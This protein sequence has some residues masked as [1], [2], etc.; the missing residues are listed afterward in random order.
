MLSKSLADINLKSTMSRTTC[1]FFFKD[2]DNITKSNSAALSVLLHQLFQAKPSLIHNAMDAYEA[3]EETGG[4]AQSFHQLWAVLKKSARDPEAGEIICI[5]DALDECAEGDRNELINTL[6]DFYNP[7]SSDQNH[8]KLKFFVTSR[9]YRDIEQEFIALTKHFPTIRIRGEHESPAI[10]NDI[11]FVVQQKISELKSDLMLTD[12][13]EEKFKQGLQNIKQRTFLWATLIIPFIRDRFNSLNKY[14]KA[15]IRTL[16]PTVEKEYQAILS[17]IKDFNR[18]TARKLLLILVGAARPLSLKELNI[19]LAIEEHHK[20]HEDLRLDPEKRFKITVRDLCGLFVTVID[21]KAFL[22]HQTA[23]DFLLAQSLDSAT[24]RQHSPELETRWQHSLE[25]V[26]SELVMARSCIAY[27]MLAVYNDDLLFQRKNSKAA[28]NGRAEGHDFLDYAASFWTTHF[29]KAQSI[30]TDMTSRSALKL[31]DTRSK[32]FENWFKKYWEIRHQRYKSAPQLCCSLMVA[33]YFGHDA[34]VTLLLNTSEVEVN[35]KDIN[36]RTPLGWA[37]GNGRE[38]VVELLLDAK[39]DVESKDNRF[40]LTPLSCAAGNGHEAVIK[41]LLDAKADVKSKSGMFYQ[42][43]LS[44]AA[45]YGHEAVV[46]LLLD[47]KADVESKDNNGLTPLSWAAGNGHKAVIKLLLDA[48][49]N[50]ESKD[51]NDR[52]PLSWAAENGH[53]AVVKLLLDAKGDVKSKRSDGRTPL[54]WAAGN[55]HEAVI[56]LLLDAKGDVKSKDNSGQTPLSWAAKNTGMKPSLSCYLMLKP[57]SSLRIV[58][59]ERRYHGL[60]KTS[61][62]PSL[63]YCSMLKPTSS[64]RI[65]VVK[66]RYRGPPRMGARPSL[67]CFSMLKATSS[68]RITMVERRYGGPPST[69]TTPSSSCC[70]VRPPYALDSH[71]T[72]LLITQLCL[73]IL[74]NIE[75]CFVLRRRLLCLNQYVVY[76]SLSILNLSIKVENNLISCCIDILL[77]APNPPLNLCISINISQI[78][79]KIKTHA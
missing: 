57:T 38:A 8:C 75:E 66:R 24:G 42:T 52:T 77:F 11:N 67:S 6:K 47:A 69:G 68:R 19:A 4:L 55:G 43:P 1:Y 40:G 60:L 65:N 15:I 63:S 64:R 72:R 36:G 35:A 21:Q 54:S 14:L 34:M 33:S 44:W 12:E 56:K 70:R 31:C 61:E 18:P 39:A 16:P 76:V 78:I 79:L 46:K 27:L 62:K 32:R 30:A 9:P 59:V 23:K 45:R 58:V 13:E 17:K 26:E 2:D 29:R 22:I 73:Y 41:L 10:S 7:K 49:A 48:K 28:V 25:P 37:A 3:E 71:S 53:E 20:S 50:V 5:L 74:D 51:N